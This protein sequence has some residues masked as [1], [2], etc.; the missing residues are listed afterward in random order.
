MHKAQHHKIPLPHIV[1]VNRTIIVRHYFHVT[2]I[3]LKILLQHNI[4]IHDYSTV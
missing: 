3:H 1:N 4:A 2:F